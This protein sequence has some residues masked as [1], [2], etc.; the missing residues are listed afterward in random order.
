[1][2]GIEEYSDTLDSG[3]SKFLFEIGV[4]GVEEYS[5]T[6]HPKLLIGV[7]LLKE[8]FTEIEDLRSI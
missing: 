5:D 1:M 4:L 7:F 3:K 2:P 6:I 8:N